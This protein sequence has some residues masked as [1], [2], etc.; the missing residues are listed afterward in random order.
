MISDILFEKLN[1]SCG[2]KDN[3]AVVD[4]KRALSYEELCR[5]T[6]NIYTYLKREGLRKGD[7]VAVFLPNCVEFV[8]SFFA[9]S[10]LG[11][12][13]VPINTKFGYSEI[14][15]YISAT[16]ANYLLYYGRRSEEI[17]KFESFENIK[18]INIADELSRC[19]ADNPGLNTAADENYGSSDEKVLYLFSTGSTGKPKCIARNHYNLL[20]LAENHTVTAGLTEHDN[21]LMAIPLS[22]TYGFGNFISA[23]KAGATIYLSDGFSRKKILSLISS[24]NITV[25]PAVPFMLDSLVSV[26]N[27]GNLNFDSLRLVISAGSPLP[28]KIFYSFGEKFGIYP[29]Q[30]YGSSETGVISINVSSNIKE[31]HNSVGRPVKDVVVKVVDDRGN[32]PGTGSEGEI[33]VRSPSMTTGYEGMEEETEKAFRGGFYYTGDIGRI[34]EEGYIFITG[35]KKLFIN[36]SGFKV[37]PVELENFLMTNEN[38]R[39]VAVTGI[40]DGQGHEMI[41]A[42]IVPRNKMSYVDV[43]RFCRGKIADQKIPKIIEF[44]DALPK[45]PTGKTLR[46]RL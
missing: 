34:D 39:D 18:K 31:T 42:F 41:K 32:D 19:Y 30:L 2:S 27:T 15:H 12:I 28:E 45:S 8:A 14:A 6:E 23:I 44:R 46:S 5:V 29:R 36:V 38:I 25:F 10:K 7:A 43:F 3:I 22:H 9:A 26:K 40:R 33:I 13:S 11:A 16:D 17:N 4:G 35:R 21:V 1:D 37:D 20:S 24:N